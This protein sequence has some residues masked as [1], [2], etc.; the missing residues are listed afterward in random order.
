MVTKIHLVLLVQWVR[1]SILLALSA[2]GQ[3]WHVSD[4]PSVPRHL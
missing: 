3:T 2:A 4:S 1:W